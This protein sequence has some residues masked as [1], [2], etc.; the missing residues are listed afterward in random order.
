MVKLACGR[1]AE[2]EEPHE[3]LALALELPI[4]ILKGAIAAGCRKAGFVQIM[5]HRHLACDDHV[6][7]EIGL[8]SVWSIEELLATQI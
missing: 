3:G 4:Q 7:R 6:H 8:P 5:E 2:T 1:G